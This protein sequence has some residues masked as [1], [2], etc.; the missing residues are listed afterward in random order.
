[1]NNGDGKRPSFAS[2]TPE[3]EQKL[4]DLEKQL[5]NVYVIAYEQPLV[6][7]RLADDEMELLQDAEKKMPGVVLVAYRKTKA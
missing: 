4:H 2:L 5:G 6:P 7:A 1:M 3:Q